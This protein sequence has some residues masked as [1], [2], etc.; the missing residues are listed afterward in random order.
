MDRAEAAGVARSPSSRP[1]RDLQ[2]P[3][4]ER[5]DRRLVRAIRSRDRGAKRAGM[6]VRG[7]VSCAFGCPYEGPVPPEAAAAVSARL[8]SAG[9][10]EISIGDTIGVA[11]PT[12][13]P[14]VCGRTVEAGVPIGAVALHFHDTRG[15][16]LANVVEGLRAGVRIFDASAGGLGGCPDYA[17]GAA[18][19]ATGDL[20]HLLQG[21]AGNGVPGFGTSPRLRALSAVTGR[22]PAS[23]SSRRF[24]GR[25]MR[26]SRLRSTPEQDVFVLGRRV[27]MAATGF[28]SR[29]TAS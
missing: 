14:D 1:L 19:N 24:G 16:A 5:D 8:F 11:V 21:W 10:D 4:H 18:G 23:A 26:G 3:E 15:T 17:S 27:R 28:S 6:R 20:L 9:C 7:Y 22:V 12:Q 13:V 2:F 29:T 25:G